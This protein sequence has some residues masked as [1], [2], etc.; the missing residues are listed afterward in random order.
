MVHRHFTADPV[1]RYRRRAGPGC[2]VAVAGGRFR[3]V[4]L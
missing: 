4:G 1:N 3:I 2:A